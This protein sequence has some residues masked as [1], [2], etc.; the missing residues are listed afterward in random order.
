[1]RSKVW[2]LVFPVAE[3]DKASYLSVPSVA[4]VEGIDNAEAVKFAF[5]SF[6]VKELDGTTKPL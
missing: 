2:E 4:M 5:T 1:M 6:I 3:L